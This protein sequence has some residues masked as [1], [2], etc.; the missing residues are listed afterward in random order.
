MSCMTSGKTSMQLEW[1]TSV[2]MRLQ[3]RMVVGTAFSLFPLRSTSSSSSS[4]AI[5]LRNR[6]NWFDENIHSEKCMSLWTTAGWINNKRKWQTTQEGSW[7]IFTHKDK[8][9]NQNILIWNSDISFEINQSSVF[10]N[11]NHKNYFSVSPCHINVCLLSIILLIK[12]SVNNKCEWL[13]FVFN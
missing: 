3:F 2:C 10:L 11:K 12:Y 6:E 7:Y 4:L 1:A 13:I 8:L 5:L 9:L